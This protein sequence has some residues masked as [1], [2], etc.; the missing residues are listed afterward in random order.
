MLLKEFDP[1]RHVMWPVVSMVYLSLVNQVE[2]FFETVNS[3]EDQLN[4]LR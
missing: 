4:N 1:I 3:P 2:R